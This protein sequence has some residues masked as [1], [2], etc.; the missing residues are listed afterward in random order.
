MP[1]PGSEEG[2]LLT[3]ERAAARETN[4]LRVTVALDEREEKRVEARLAR[5]GR[6]VG[7]FDL[8]HAAVLQPFEMALRPADADAVMD[9]GVRLVMT[10]GTKPLWL[11]AD[12]GQGADACPALMPHLLLAGRTDP[13]A[14]FHDRML[15]LATLTPFGWIEGCVLD[16]LLAM[17]RGRFGDRARETLERHLSLYLTPDKHLVY[18]SPMSQPLRDT[19]YGIEAHLP[20]A[21][22]ASVWPDHPVLDLAVAYLRSKRDD[23]GAIIDR[24]TTT[25]EGSYIVAYPLA[26]IARARKSSELAEWART[27]LRVRQRRLAVGGAIYQRAGQDGA[28]SYRNWTRGVAWYLLGIVRTLDT[29]NEAPADLVAEAARVAA[30]VQKHQRPD[31]LWPCYVDDPGLLSDTSGSAGIAAALALGASKGWFAAPAREAAART[32]GGLIPHLT[33]D[34]FLGGVAQ[35]NKGGEALQRSDYR[36]LSQM[37]MGL[38]AQLEAALAPTEG[39]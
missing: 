3:W 21:V 9:E 7:A 31:G 28:R 14:A 16:G 25:T 10:K 38:M 15:S 20:L 32:W 24:G 17:R 39:P 1:V 26:A 12:T 37:A 23:D 30:W 33:P 36:V 6:V 22:V 27:Q 5:S 29:L 2:P 19:F 13:V 11:F 4:R 8:R 18:E 35:Y 34:G